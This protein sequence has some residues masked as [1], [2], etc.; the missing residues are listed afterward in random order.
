M[1]RFDPLLPLI[2]Y[3][4]IVVPSSMPHLLLCLFCICQISC[5]NYGDQELNLSSIHLP[6]QISGTNVTYK[7]HGIIYWKGNEILGHGHYTVEFLL[8]EAGSYFYDDT[9]YGRA[10]H[11][12]ENVGS[13]LNGRMRTDNMSICVFVRTRV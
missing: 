10:N 13:M 2:K 11:V 4:A 8:P 1:Q 6:F 5:I 3:D 7:L 12:G 9:D